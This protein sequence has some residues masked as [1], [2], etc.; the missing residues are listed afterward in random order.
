MESKLSQADDIIRNHV[1]WATGAGVVPLPLIDV[2]AVTSVQLDMLKQLCK[3]YEVNY[4]ENSGKHLITAIAGTTLARLGASFIKAIPGVGS[5]L[6]GVSMGVLSGASTYGMGQVFVNQ[7]EQGRGLFDFDL[8]WGKKVYE[9]EY[10]KGKEYASNVQKKEEGPSKGDVFKKL[11]E[12]LNLKKQGILTEE[13]FNKKK[14]EL[15]KKL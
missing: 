1:L 13:E 10:E 11:D 6:G 4:D 5:L 12:L 7:F 14:E 3:L 2:I 9:Q 8:N 15:L